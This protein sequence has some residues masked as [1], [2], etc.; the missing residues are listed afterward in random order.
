[1]ICSLLV[2]CNTIKTRDQIKKP[3]QQTRT[4]HTTEP[5]IEFPTTAQNETPSAQPQP[6]P[7]PM[8]SP[9]PPSA[10]IPSATP[11]PPRVLPKIGVILGPGGMKTFAH[12]GVL[13]EM[14]RARIPVH[15]IV[16]LEWGAVM[17][18]A[19]ATQGQINDAEWKAF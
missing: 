4:T 11:L 7:V 18:G 2:G 10:P 16:G 3:P 6:T 8:A 17:A 14:N 13:R 15:A 19:F 5:G 12:L 9:P 1:L